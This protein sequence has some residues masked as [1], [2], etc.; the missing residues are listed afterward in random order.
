MSK[1]AQSELSARPAADTAAKDDGYLTG[2]FLI[3]SPSMR[4]ARFRGGVIFM[5]VHDEEHAMGIMINKPK[6]DLHLSSMLPHLEIDGDVTNEDT[7]IL[8]GGPVETERG[9][10]LHSE[11]YKDEKNSLPLSDTLSMTTSKSVLTALTKPF[12][13]R[14]AVLALGYTGWNAGQLESEI[15]RNSWLI[16]PAD[17][18]LIFGGKPED[19]WKQALAALGIAPEQLSAVAGNA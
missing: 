2:K 10:V 19:K 1:R 9:F 8:Y 7:P 18:A 5:C 17:E 14:K 13:P 3:A 6:P 15:M 12:A 4:D 16:G 11:D